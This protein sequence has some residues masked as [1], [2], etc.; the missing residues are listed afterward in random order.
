MKMETYE[1]P[2]TEGSKYYGLKINLD[3]DG[4]DR[5]TDATGRWEGKRLAL[6]IDD[7]LIDVPLVSSETAAGVTIVN[8]VNQTQ[9]DAENIKKTLESEER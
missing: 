9:E 3:Q 7:S 4:K 6:I 8:G 1:I 2:N 5:W